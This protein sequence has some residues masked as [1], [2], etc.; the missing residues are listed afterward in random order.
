MITKLML[1]ER[2]REWGLR[3]EVV[4][5]DYVLGW[6]LWGIGS[7]KELSVSW[8]FK[9]GTCLKKCYIETYRFS[10]DL[11][12]T[13]LPGGPVQAAELGTIIGEVL[14]RVGDESGIN[15]SG[16]APLFKTHDSGRYTEGR[17]YYQGPRNAP[18]VAS[19]KLD[20]SSSEKVAR[21]TVLRKIA[22][23]YPD[24][25][26]EPGSVRCYSFEEIFAE[27]IRAMGE[28]GRPRDLYDIVNLFRRADLRGEPELIRAVL[29]EKCA[30][31]GV[32]VPTFDTIALGTIP[33]ELE[34][35]WAN[36]LAHQLPALP[37]FENFWAELR[38]LFA[39][40]NQTLEVQPL[41]SVP[42]AA[43]EETPAMWSPPSTIWTWGAGVPLET[44][45]FAAAN[46]LCVNLGYQG[47]TRI[48][49]P[50]SLR[51]TREGKLVLHAVKADTRESRSYRIDRIQSVEVTTR[52]FTPVYQI[53]FS[54]TGSIHAPPT[55][56]NPAR[57]S[58]R[59]SAQWRAP[60]WV[61]T[62]Q[63]PLCRRTFR[64]TKRDATLNPHKDDSGYPCRGKRGYIVDQRYE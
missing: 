27:K 53:E 25:L 17:I 14:R 60:G 29:V 48:I 23:I 6:L 26:P 34:A 11:D 20:L 41:E 54:S 45:R 13:V 64:R 22:H 56:T 1:E 15:F 63:C 24:N 42:L 5:K 16:R 28:R 61:Y 30:T 62:V 2:V 47:S 10:E 55:T 44:I 21:P 12:F 36:M 4:E 52:P 43:E 57:S 19:V 46:R 59:K 8:A 37:P 49:E 33:A 18:T 31:K 7:H 50:Y 40:L 38:N 39:W 35:D 3:E 9:G 51:R 58:S 32:G